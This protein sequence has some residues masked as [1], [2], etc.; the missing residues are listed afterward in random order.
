MAVKRL[1]STVSRN[2]RRYGAHLGDYRRV[3]HKLSAEI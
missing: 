3:A 2:Y 1:E